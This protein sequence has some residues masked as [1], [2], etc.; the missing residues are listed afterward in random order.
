MARAVQGPAVECQFG[1]SFLN[2]WLNGRPIFF[3]LSVAIL[4]YSREWDANLHCDLRLGDCRRNAGLR[5]WINSS[6]V[7]MP[8]YA[9]T[10]RTSCHTLVITCVPGRE[11][12]RF[13][14]NNNNSVRCFEEKLQGHVTTN[15]HNPLHTF[16]RYF[17]VD[18]LVA[19]LLR[20]CRLCC[21]LVVEGKWCNG[22]WP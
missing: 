6:R 12:H 2:L 18:Q 19:D 4:W 22:F 1:D 8:L 13:S 3:T 16:P 20:T 10:Q 11:T 14:T 5:A 15:D 7:W 9:N 21:R 17:P